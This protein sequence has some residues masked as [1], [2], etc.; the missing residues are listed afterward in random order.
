MQDGMLQKLFLGTLASCVVGKRT[1][2]MLRGTKREIDCVVKMILAA[3]KFHEI[4]MSD[5]NDLK[6]ILKALD[7]KMAVSR[8]F[9]DIFGSR[10]P[11]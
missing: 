6:A 5:S 2:V 9:E 4:I 11:L 8:E 1:N 3:R 7:E 10:F